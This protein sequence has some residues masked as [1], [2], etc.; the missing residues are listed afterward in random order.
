MPLKPKYWL[1]KLYCFP[2]SICNTPDI[3]LFR[4]C[5][6]SNQAH[7]EFLLKRARVG[8]IFHSF[9]NKCLLFAVHH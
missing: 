3:N 8:C 6:L 7:L 5:I 4:G 1:N 9:N 2:V